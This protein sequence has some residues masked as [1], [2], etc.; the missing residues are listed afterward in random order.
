MTVSQG[1]VIPAVPDGSPPWVY[2][3]AVVAA[4]LVVFIGAL[5]TIIEKVRGT[6]TQPPPPVPDR[7]AGSTQPLKA[8]EDGSPPTDTLRS[9]IVDLQG[10][11]TRSEQREDELQKN[12]LEMTRSLATAEAGLASAREEIERLRTQIQMLTMRRG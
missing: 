6:G 3:V 5:P 12:L 2:V 7:P 9:M 11:L 1:T 10:R 4:L 8:I